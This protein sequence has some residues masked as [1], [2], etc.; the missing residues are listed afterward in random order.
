[1]SSSTER[2]RNKIVRI[3][4]ACHYNRLFVY[5]IFSLNNIFLTEETCSV[6]RFLAAICPKLK[7]S[8]PWRIR[9]R[10]IIANGFDFVEVFE[11]EV[12][13]FR[14]LAVLVNV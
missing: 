4:L 2:K 5:N 12:R 8:G 1:M 7:S 6:T 9:S 11:L 10:Y 3:L 14:F 13:I